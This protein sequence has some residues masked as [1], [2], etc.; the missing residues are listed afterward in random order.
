MRAAENISIIYPSKYKESD[1]RLKFIHRWLAE[2]CSSRPVDRVQGKK[3]FT[4]WRS[5]ERNLYV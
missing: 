4:V 1:A 2:F 5:A 3:F